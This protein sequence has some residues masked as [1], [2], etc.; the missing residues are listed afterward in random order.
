MQ[1]FV[2][3]T[4]IETSGRTLEEVADVFGDGIKGLGAVSGIAALT[5]GKKYNDN[6]EYVE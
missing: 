4:F 5:D 6:A 1:F 2:S 3:F